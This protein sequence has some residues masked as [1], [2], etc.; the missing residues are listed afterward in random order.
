MWAALAPIEALTCE[1]SPLSASLLQINA[2]P[3]QEALARPRQ[4][5]VTTEGSQQV[6]LDHRVGNHHTEASREMVIA[7][8]RQTDRIERHLC[9]PRPRRRQCHGHQSLDDLPNA[10]RSQAE[11]TMATL[12]LHE[13]QPRTKELGEVTACGLWRDAGAVS[14][15]LGR[16]RPPVHQRAE[17]PCAHGVTD[18]SRDTSD[19]QPC[20][21]SSTVVDVLRL[22]NNPRAR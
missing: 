3:P 19:V 15:L 22:Y 10:R 6:S 5:E 4:N 13:D 17:H 12:S 14:E 16:P 21:H 20:I 1:S 2:E 11:V 8:T 9:P 7:G 18:Q